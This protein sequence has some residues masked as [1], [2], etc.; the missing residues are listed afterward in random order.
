[1]M[2]KEIKVS[3]L[4]SYRGTLGFYN[5]VLD[6]IVEGRPKSKLPDLVDNDTYIG[7]EIE[8]EQVLRT[9]GILSVSSDTSLWRNVEDGSLRNNGKEFVSL[10]IKGKHIKLALDVFNTTM[11]RE[12]ACIGHEFSDRTSVHVH[13]NIRDLT[14]EHFSNFLITYVLVEPLLYSWASEERSKGVFCVPISQSK[15]MQECLGSFLNKFESD[16]G[17]IFDALGNWQKYTGFNLLPIYNF[18]TIEFRHMYGTKDPEV[19]IKWINIIFSLKKF[20]LSQDYEKLKDRISNINTTSEYQ[21]IVREIFGDLTHELL[22]PE[23]DKTLENTAITLKTIFTYSRERIGKTLDDKTKRELSTD[24]SGNKFI[25]LCIKQGWLKGTSR[26]EQI[27]ECHYKISRY[28]KELNAWDNQYNS[29]DNILSGDSKL[30]GTQQKQFRQDYNN[31]VKERMKLLSYI[32]IEKNKIL[33]L[34]QGKSINTQVEEEIDLDWLN[35]IA[36]PRETRIENARTTAFLAGTQTTTGWTFP[37]AT[38]SLAS[39][40]DNDF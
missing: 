14:L 20:A 7:L 2:N 36:M 35:P 33:S 8:V 9:H 16:K 30:T 5:T 11:C 29:Y 31:V 10:P 32:A 28:Q 34:K 22:V 4:L 15:D 12:K 24:I 3:E 27:T 17:N 23:L 25:S 1:M 6:L 40:T 39:T 21:F 38:P 26:E 13:M 19:L 18:G 37:P